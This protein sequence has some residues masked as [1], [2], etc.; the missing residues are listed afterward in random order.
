MFSEINI[1]D[2]KRKKISAVQ[3]KKENQQKDSIKEKYTVEQQSLTDVNDFSDEKLLINLLKCKVEGKFM[4]IE[5]K[6]D[7]DK[8]ILH[9]SLFNNKYIEFDEKD[10]I[11]SFRY[12]NFLRNRTTKKLE[13]VNGIIQMTISN[14][15]DFNQVRIDA[16][17]VKKLYHKSK[18][19]MYSVDI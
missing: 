8:Y 9:F 12:D 17:K 19:K 16:L 13:M 4:S 14:P 3:I 15:I 5:Y 6:I 18:N 7:R 11:I 10:Q 2:K 1:F